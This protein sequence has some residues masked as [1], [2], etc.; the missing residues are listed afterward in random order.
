MNRFLNFLFYATLLFSCLNAIRLRE[1]E[2]MNNIDYL[3]S[4]YN[5]FKGNP[6]PLSGNVDP[7][8]ED[9]IFQVSYTENRLTGDHRFVVPDGYSIKKNQA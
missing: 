4:G 8:F 1:A 9:L 6:F 2:K 7:G 5:I 3:F